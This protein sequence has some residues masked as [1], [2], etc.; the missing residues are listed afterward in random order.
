MESE[1]PASSH[2]MSGNSE[3]PAQAGGSSIADPAAVP[4]GPGRESYDSNL[5]AGAIR[6]FSPT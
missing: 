6:T 1:K 5:P 3:R 4:I 2:A